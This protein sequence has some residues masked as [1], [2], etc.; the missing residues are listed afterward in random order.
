L[1]DRENAGGGKGL[2][3]DKSKLAAVADYVLDGAGSET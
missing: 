1:D 2:L 3:E